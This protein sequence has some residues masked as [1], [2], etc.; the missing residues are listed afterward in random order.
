MYAISLWIYNIIT[1]Y[2]PQ[3]D[4]SSFVEKVY[5]CAV[6]VFNTYCSL[7]FVCVLYFILYGFVQYERN[8]YVSKKLYN[9]TYTKLQISSHNTKI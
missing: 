1:S 5:L 7:A 4:V 3:Y 6:F 8:I 2:S 9:H